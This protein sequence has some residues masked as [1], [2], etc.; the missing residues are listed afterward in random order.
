MGSKIISILQNL[1]E[2]RCYV[3][4]SYRN[5]EIHHVMSGTANRKLSTKYGL[6]LWLCADHHRGRLGVHN[7]YILKERLEKDAQRA[8]EALYGHKQWMQ[9]FR[10]NYL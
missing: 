4:G 3:C 10:K 2:P 9:T 1:D 8:F 5:L 6:V 7:D